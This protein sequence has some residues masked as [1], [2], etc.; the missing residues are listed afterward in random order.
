MHHRRLVPL[1]LA[2]GWMLLAAC[3]H[4]PAPSTPPPATTDGASLT[5]AER[6]ALAGTWV[7]AGGDA[8]LAAVEPAVDKATADMGF[9]ARPFAMEAL[10]PRAQPR[11]RYTLAFEGPTVN[12]ASP[13]HPLERGNLGGPPVRVTDKFGDE[14]D[15][16]FR[17]RDGALVEAGKGADG[18]G[19]TVFTPSADGQTLS[20]RRLMQSSRL[21][22]PV[23][24]TYSYRRQQ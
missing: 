16:T 6:K 4:A 22:A 19:E 12:I 15:T 21:S 3:A 18:S 2:L 23:E 7:Y 10:R 14:N 24:L 1:R 8:E 5:D 17:V 11:Q 20:V 9:L 13:D